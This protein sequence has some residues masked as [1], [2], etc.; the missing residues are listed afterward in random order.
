MLYTYLDPKERQRELLKLAGVNLM[1]QGKGSRQENR[2]GLFKLLI[3]KL[4][5]L[6]SSAGDR[7]GEQY[8]SPAAG[9]AKEV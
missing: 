4:E 8:I 1:S 6:L 2:T 9:R 7:L 3:G 5:N